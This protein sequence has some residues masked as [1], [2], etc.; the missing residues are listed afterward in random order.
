MSHVAVT[1]AEEFVFQA[2]LDL[3]NANVIL[4]HYLCTKRF[5]L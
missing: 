4:I 1:L 3:S 2:I 5:R